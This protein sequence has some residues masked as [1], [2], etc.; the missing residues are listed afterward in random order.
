MSYFSTAES[1]ELREV[2]RLVANAVQKG[3][4]CDITLTAAKNGD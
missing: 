1:V 4:L 3:L 2:S